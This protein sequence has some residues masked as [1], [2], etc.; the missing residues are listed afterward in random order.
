MPVMPFF[1]SNEITNV[2]NIG[3][4]I[5]VGYNS[6]NLETL[7]WRALL[8]AWMP[9]AFLTKSFKSINS[10]ASGTP[11]WYGLVRLQTD[12][13]DHNPGLVFIDFAVNDPGTSG[14][15]RTD[16]F[17]PASEAIIRKIRGALPNTKIVVLIFTKPE[18]YTAGVGT[19]AR[20]AWIN[21]AAT[22]GL[23]VY[24]LDTYLE[25][26]MPVPYSDE[27]IDVYYTVSDVHPIDAGHAA[28]AAQV[29]AGLTSL[30]NPA[31]N[32]LPARIYA[33]SEDYEQDPIIRTG[34]DNDG[35]T[36]TWVTSGTARQS[37]T[38]NSTISWTGT[39]C[40]FGLDT[41]NGAGGGVLA[42][43]VDGGGYTN[44]DTENTKSTGQ[45]YA[46]WNTTRN[47]HTVTIKVVSGT[48]KI[49]RFLAI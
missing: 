12:L 30:T 17:I 38:A 27:D 3:G 37:S 1:L 11:S 24:R 6:T 46:V 34:I 22:Y 14:G 47:V 7:S 18:N 8:R 23:E 32:P 4:S 41:L 19:V 2:V 9:G 25:T 39:F 15:E 40:S 49:N 48:V 5:T 10:G 31:T 36:G 43:D 28:I 44:I 20:D 13:I 16:D 29:E 42:W 21:I 33:E 26:L 45:V 35:E